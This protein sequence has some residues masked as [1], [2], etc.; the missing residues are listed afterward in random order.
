MKPGCLPRL[1]MMNRFRVLEHTADVGFEA[2]GATRAEAIANAA[3]ALQDLTVDLSA[4]TAREELPVVAEGENGLELL[5][6]WLSRILYLFDAEGWLFSDIQVQS[7]EEGKI[8]AVGR[9]E[10]FDPVRHSVKLQVKAITYHQLALE[11]AP[12][13]WRARVFVDI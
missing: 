13:G 7:L 3:L 1:E 5:V 11:P 2:W 12:Q 10:K 4:I 8:Q 6:N 9:G